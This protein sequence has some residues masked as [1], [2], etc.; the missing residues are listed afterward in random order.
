[1]HN[2]KLSV[3]QVAMSYKD[4][5][6]FERAFRELKSGLD[7]RPIYHWKDNRVKGHVM[8]CFMALVLENS[9]I[10]LLKEHDSKASYREVFQDLSQLSA[11][12]LN[13]IDRSYLYRPKLPGLY[14]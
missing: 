3:G 11:I 13:I 4:L 5:W 2:S 6:R 1:M 7:L 12:K 8:V 9:L 14:I 10:R